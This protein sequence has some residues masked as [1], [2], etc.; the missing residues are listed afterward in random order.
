MIYVL[1][2]IC[3]TAVHGRKRGRKPG[4]GRGEKR[5][6]PGEYSTNPHTIKARQR[7]EGMT[8]AQREVEARATADATAKSRAR[9]KRRTAADWNMMTEEEQQRAIEEIDEAVDN[10]R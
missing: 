3:S 8:A 1:I 2:I 10:K 7:R 6:K 5:K 4:S 9:K